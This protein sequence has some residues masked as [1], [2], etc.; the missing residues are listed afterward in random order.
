MS[1]GTTVRDDIGNEHPR[2]HLRLKERGE[3]ELKRLYSEGEEKRA[4]ELELR[5]QPI[6]D[7]P[8][9][10]ALRTAREEEKAFLAGA[11]ER[12][13][14]CLSSLEDR[15]PRIREWTCQLQ[16][17]EA[18]RDFYEPLVDMSYDFELAYQE[19]RV[20]SKELPIV[21]ALRHELLDELEEAE[22]DLSLVG[23]EDQEAALNE[24]NEYRRKRKAACSEEKKKIRQQHREG[25]ISSKALHNEQ[26]RAERSAEEDILTKKRL[27]PLPKC[28]D[29][30][31]HIKH[32][33]K[34]DIDSRWRVIHSD[35]SDI[36]RKTPIEV[37]KR[38]PWLSLL[39]FPI[40]GLGQLLIGQRQ[41]AFF[42][43]LGTLFIYLAAIPYSLGVGNYRGKGIAGLIS[44][45]KGGARLDR[46]IIFMIEGVIAVIFL[47]LA[48]LI[49]YL[50][51]RD[52][53]STEKR[54]IAG[55]R[56]HNWFETRM[57]MR[58]KGFPYFVSAPAAI[59][60]IFI[61]LL[62]IAVTCLI[63][64]TNYDPTHQ[65]KFSWTGLEN[66]K[67]IFLGQGMAG[68][69]FWHIMG[70]TLIWTLAATTLAIFIGF[71][72]A[73]LVNQDRIRGKKFFRTVYLLPWAVPAFITI[74]FFSIM[75]S[76]S[77]PLTVALNQFL[78]NT[79][80]SEMLNIKYTTWGTR[81]VLILLQGWLG[82]SYVFLLCTGILQGIPN[83]LYEAARI[84]GA[85]GFQQTRYITIPLLLFQTAP[86]MIG[87]YTFNFNNFSIIY[88]FNGGGPFEPSKYGNLAG[89]SDLLISYIYKLTIQKQYQGI[90]SAI[91][92]IVSLLLIFITWMGFR[93][94]KSFREEKL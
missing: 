36:R 84:D 52:V 49:L 51:Y 40:P 20:V 48:F 61:V 45:A 83:D 67:A 81:I 19:N 17:S 9:E 41:K 94:T 23:K 69:P 15:D 32:R 79:D 35:I 24:F 46:S 4:I 77:G 11:R 28:R 5:T 78:G 2:K 34:V 29:R 7:H 70:W 12:R 64:F 56:K 26:K 1:Y 59:L 88:L 87:Q 65:S 54:M 80:P 43:F 63:S 50:S 30:V 37:K 42:F 74:M 90:G 18:R 72:L 27:L 93:R 76:P 66:Y 25:L 85:Q 31:R 10:Q 73:L 58:G 91:T 82:S 57:V 3:L 39:T 55:I 8:Y 75:F 14:A 53:R 60:T 6:D 21:I 62:P 44:L 38:H 16:E 33:L 92:M 13:A 86:L 89:S 47:V 68:G 71:V 22:K